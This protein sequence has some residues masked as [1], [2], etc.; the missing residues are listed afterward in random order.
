MTTLSHMLIVERPLAN[1]SVA[2]SRMLVTH[3]PLNRI[4][5]WTSWRKLFRLCLS[6][7]SHILHIQMLQSNS[8][9]E[10]LQPAGFFLV[11]YTTR[12]TLDGFQGGL[13]IGGRLVTL[14][15]SSCWQLQRQNYTGQR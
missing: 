14:M 12:E 5:R 11:R 10:V 4:Q 13:Q 8:D 15:T 6:D 7:S 2:K 9:V 1:R 3:Q